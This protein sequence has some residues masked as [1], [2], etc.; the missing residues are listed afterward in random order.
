M[1]KGDTFNLLTG[2][3]IG[4]RWTT[5]WCGWV[6][7]QEGVSI[8]R[9]ATVYHAGDTGYKNNTGACPIFKGRTITLCE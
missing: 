4:D 7:H 9:P 8:R 1:K 2:R 6:V 5:L 3:S